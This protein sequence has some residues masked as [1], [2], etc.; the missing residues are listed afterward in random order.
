MLHSSSGQ[1]FLERVEL[2]LNKA[3]ELQKVRLNEL[4]QV[5]LRHQAEM[6]RLSKRQN[7]WRVSLSRIKTTISCSHYIYSAI[8]LTLNL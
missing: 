7:S 8:V 3:L 1:V 5:K 6:L 2:S 4:F